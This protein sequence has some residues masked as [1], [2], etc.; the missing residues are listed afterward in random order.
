V[1]ATLLIDGFLILL[2]I[3]SI[4]APRFDFSLAKSV[5]ASD[6]VASATSSGISLLSDVATSTNWIATSGR[7][8]IMWDAIE[9]ARCG[10]DW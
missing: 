7:T 4:E 1:V 3:A 2:P 8:E 5:A 6:R 10:D 9:I